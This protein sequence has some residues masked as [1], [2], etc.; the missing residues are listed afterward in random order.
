MSLKELFA[1]A[2]SGTD[3]LK[4][5]EKHQS[6]KP[7][8]EPLKKQIHHQQF[9]DALQ[10][11]QKTYQE[12][13]SQFRFIIQDLTKR[14]RSRLCGVAK[15]SFNQ[16]ATPYLKKFSTAFWAEMRKYRKQS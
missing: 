15:T 12:D 14:E 2:L 16:E 7:L 1:E 11:L 4:D 5:V 3:L 13:I 8:V 10:S 9:D 6:V